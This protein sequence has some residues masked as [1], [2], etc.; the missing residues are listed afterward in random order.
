MVRGVML[1]V[2]L[3]VVVT[4]MWVLVANATDHGLGVLAIVV[5]GAVG[6]GVLAGARGR[7]GAR[8]GMVAAGLTLALVLAGRFTIS[9]ME[10][11]RW[12]E[13]ARAITEEDCLAHVAAGIQERYLEN[14]YDLTWNEASEFPIEV[15]HAAQAKWSRMNEAERSGVRATLE[16]RANAEASSAPLVGAV[17]FLVEF[18]LWG[19]AGAALGM[20]T[21]YKAASATIAEAEVVTVASTA[22]GRIEILTE[23]LREAGQAGIFGALGRAEAAREAKERNGSQA[24]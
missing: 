19:W 21:A 2:A 8:G 11:A 18:G 24:A 6:G 4:T 23:D 13:E 3:G 12:A 17:V 22:P 10:A 7:G 20:A 9:Q 15:M 16:E 14:E 1:G 5:G